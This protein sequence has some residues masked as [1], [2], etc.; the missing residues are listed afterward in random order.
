M[1]KTTAKGRVREWFAAQADISDYFRTPT[2]TEPGGLR[3][4]VLA[5]YPE[6]Q[7]QVEFRARAAF[8]PVAMFEQ[9]WPEAE[10]ELVR[11]FDELGRRG[12]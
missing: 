4:T 10:A 3:L 2:E 8:W 12:A 7:L 5:D 1:T 9:R 11:F 6:P